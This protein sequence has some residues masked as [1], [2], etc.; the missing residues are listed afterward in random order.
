MN[1]AH[2]TSQTNAKATINVTTIVITVTVTANAMTDLMNWIVQVSQL[3]GSICFCFVEYQLYLQNSYMYQNFDTNNSYT[4]NV[5][6]IWI[7]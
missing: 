3:I 4:L 1:C 6:V 5:S 7:H 2:Y